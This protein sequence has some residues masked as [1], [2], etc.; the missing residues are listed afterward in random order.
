MSVWK[1]H[2]GGAAI[3]LKYAG[4]DATLVYEP[5]HPRDA[6]QKNL[7]LS[8][9]LG[10]LDSKSSQL[11]DIK[12]ESRQQTK[13]E[14]RVQQALK[15]RPPLNRLLT[16]ADIEVFASLQDKRNRLT[17]SQHVAAKV[18]PHKSLAYYS[19]G[20]DDEIGESLSNP[21][22]IHLLMP[23]P[24]PTSKTPDPSPVSSSTPGF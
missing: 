17:T 19:T 20:A 6:L 2:P 14:L 16:V 1:E 15:E 22:R 13:D 10:P 11:L 21:T 7:P 5:I 18:L 9:H 4:R 23:I 3:I 24:Q 12:R 8:K